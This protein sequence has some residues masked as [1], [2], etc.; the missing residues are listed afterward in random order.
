MFREIVRYTGLFGD[1]ICGLFV[2][3]SVQ[4]PGPG[5]WCV[6]ACMSCDISAFITA[7]TGTVFTSRHFCIHFISNLDVYIS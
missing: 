2:R 6:A 1:V 4:P 5:V 3:L 7:I